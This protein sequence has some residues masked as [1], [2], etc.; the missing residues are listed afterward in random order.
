MLVKN[1]NFSLC[2]TLVGIV[3]SDLTFLFILNLLL[4][5]IK[6]LSNLNHV[7]IVIKH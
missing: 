1:D 7:S 3:L 5:A 4:I 6:Q 2:N